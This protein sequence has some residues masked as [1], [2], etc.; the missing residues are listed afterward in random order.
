MRERLIARLDRLDREQ[1]GLPTM[2]ILLVLGSVRAKQYGRLRYAMSRRGLCP[3]IRRVPNDL[4]QVSAEI[5]VEV[6]NEMGA[7]A[8]DAAMASAY[9][10][11]LREYVES[12]LNGASLGD[13]KA[14]ITPDRTDDSEDVDLHARVLALL[15]EDTPSYE[16][17]VMDD[18][19]FE[20]VG[21]GY[22]DVL[23]SWS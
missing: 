6:A 14:V 3:V 16:V 7:D 17:R 19:S 2:D 21:V 1:K 8:S 5:E 9:E 11:K 18:G 10:Q 4:A 23:T 15:P 20:L 13:V 22:G 12:L